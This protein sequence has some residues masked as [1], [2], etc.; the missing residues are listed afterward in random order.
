KSRLKQVTTTLA[1]VT[2]QELLE[3]N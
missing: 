2:Q 3:N 1:A